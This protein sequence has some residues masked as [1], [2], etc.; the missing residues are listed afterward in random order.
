MVTRY[1]T[2]FFVAT[3]L[4][5]SCVD[6]PLDH[7][8]IPEPDKY[9][10]VRIQNHLPS[11]SVYIDSAGERQGYRSFVIDIINDTLLPLYFQIDFPRRY[12]DL[13]RSTNSKF[14]VFVLPDSM[15]REKE[16]TPNDSLTEGLKLVINE[17][18]KGL[19]AVRKI[20]RPGETYKLRLGS[21][22]KP[23]GL[24][25]AELFSNGHQHQ[26]SISG[27]PVKP[28]ENKNDL[29]LMLGVALYDH[30]SAITCGKISFT[31]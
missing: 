30:Y 16:Y 27:N 8:N 13:D 11:G 17:R 6:T 9:P 5:Y 25:R 10:G 15:T 7:H 26:L 19:S 2:C 28:T 4:Y 24:A 22:F 18:I 1:K 23:D 20:I 21:L 12:I 3:I 31:H 14:K 29:D